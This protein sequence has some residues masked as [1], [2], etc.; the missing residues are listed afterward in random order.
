MVITRSPAIGA[1]GGAD[2]EH[3]GHGAGERVH[4]LAGQRADRTV[5]G[6]D[7]I[8]HVE[9]EPLEGVHL[10]PLLAARRGRGE[11]LMAIGPT[12]SD[13]EHAPL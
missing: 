13:G 7:P 12:T 10:L 6:H 4:Q 2:L 1:G 11:M 9:L 3:T 8:G 5:D